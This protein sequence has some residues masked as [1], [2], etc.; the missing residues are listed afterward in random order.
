M[1]PDRRLLT[2]ALLSIGTE[3][4]VGDTRDTNA[5]D[6]A[7][8][9]TGGAV[10]VRAIQAVPDALAPGAD[11]SRGAAAGRTANTEWQGT[12]RGRD[13]IRTTRGIRC[14]A[15]RPRVQSASAS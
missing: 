3:L 7:R 13:R 1:P 5:G 12:G 4:T 9:L 8:S 14:S 10:A 2:A 15:P 6:L 11:A